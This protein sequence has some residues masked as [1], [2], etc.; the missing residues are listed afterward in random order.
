MKRRLRI[1]RVLFAFGLPS[2]LLAVPSDQA[3]PQSTSG[4]V[5]AEVETA[6][7]TFWTPHR[8]M[9][10]APVEL[11]PPAGFAPAPL[12][13]APPALR[14]SEGGPGNP[15]TVWMP[16][17]PDDLVHA[18][19]DLGSLPPSDVV[20]DL[21][22][23]GGVFTESRVI[24]PNTGQQ[25]PAVDAYP[26][27]AVGKLFFFNPRTGQDLF[28]SAAT[29][30]PRVIVTAAQCVTQGSRGCTLRQC[31][32]KNFLFIPAFDN[33]RAPFGK[34]SSSG[35]LVVS[36]AWLLSG[37]LPNPHDFAMIEAADQGGKTLGSVV[38]WLGW[39]TFRLPFNHFTTLGYPCN[40]DGC[41][42]MQRNDAQTSGFGGVNT[43]VQ[44]SDMGLGSG[45]GPWVQDL[46]L[47]PK[48]APPVP[49]GGNLIV[50]VT[51]YLAP[52]SIG[53]SQFDQLFQRMFSFL[54]R[55]QRGNC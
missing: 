53:A 47:N 46:G 39:Q 30:G 51:S 10:A 15:P 29:N 42:L 45:G 19:L 17:Q 24:P 6:S 33:G 35:F 40:L 3:A 16:P 28:C 41:M 26:Y 21:S 2:M 13:A 43:W 25:A 4:F 18:P 1:G 12:A 22:L 34:W 8:L 38:G 36:N 9:N 31:S 11:S 48:G 37:V 52:G 54:C 7:E 23:G 32:Y 14:K 50:G 55:H 49:F 27:S 44:G 5:A 20:R